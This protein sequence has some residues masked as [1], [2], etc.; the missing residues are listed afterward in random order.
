M[1]MKSAF[2]TRKRDDVL[3]TYYNDQ[4]K[5]DPAMLAMTIGC[6]ERRVVNRLS[7]LGLRSRSTTHYEQ[8]SN[9]QRRT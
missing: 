4:V 9:Y 2:L 8:K 3:R 1:L 6:I 5:V 7:Q